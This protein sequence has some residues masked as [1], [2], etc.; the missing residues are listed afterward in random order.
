MPVIE[1]TPAADA[2]PTAADQPQGKA[3]DLFVA[4]FAA[5]CFLL[6]LLSGMLNLLAG[7]WRH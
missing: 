1:P 7:I 6:I 4:W 2:A 3:D 5:V